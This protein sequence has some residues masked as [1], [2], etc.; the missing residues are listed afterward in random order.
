MAEGKRYR[1]VGVEIQQYL[2]GKKVKKKYDNGRKVKNESR[3]T[4][5]NKRVEEDKHCVY[6]SIF[7]PR[8]NCVFG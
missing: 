2:V 7:C 6:T 3:K 4:R 8:G 5:E 1:D